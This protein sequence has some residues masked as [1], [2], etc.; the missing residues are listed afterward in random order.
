M[1][2]DRDKYFA[3]FGELD[4]VRDQVDEYLAQTGH[5]ALN[6]LRHICLDPVNKVQA[7]FPGFQGEQLDTAF[8]PLQEVKG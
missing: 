7:F 5:I 3:V 8:H 6:P 1:Q 4:R 2:L